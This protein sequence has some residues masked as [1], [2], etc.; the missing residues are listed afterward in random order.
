MAALGT[1]RAEQRR[2]RKTFYGWAVIAVRDAGSGRR[3]VEATPTADN[4]YHADIFLNVVETELRDH[5]KAQALELAELSHDR[6]P[7]QPGKPPRSILHAGHVRYLEEAR[8]LGDR[9]IVAV[10]DDAS[11]ARL[12]GKGRPVN[13]LVRRL[14]VLAGLESVDCVVVFEEDTT[15]Q[16]AVTVRESNGFGP[17]R[18]HAT[19]WLASASISAHRSISASNDSP[20]SSSM[21]SASILA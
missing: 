12:K 2:P 19:D 20:S 9:L 3:W 1:K 14:R 17:W 11:V 4:P 13:G 8:A 5:Q 7:V 21:R 16:R 10:N 6:R 18:G 15:V